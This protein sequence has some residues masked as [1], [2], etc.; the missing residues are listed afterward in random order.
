MVHINM[1]YYGILLWD[2]MDYSMIMNL[3]GYWIMNINGILMVNMVN[4]N[5]VNIN[6]AYYGILLW[7]IMDYSMIMN[8]C[9][10][11]IMNI[12]GILMVNMVNINM[13]Y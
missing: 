5:M 1:A 9:G 8:L 4:I 11:W 2:I 12:N 3:C 7:D 10:Y 6:M 13:E